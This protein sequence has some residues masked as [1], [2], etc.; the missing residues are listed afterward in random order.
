[1][2][3]FVSDCPKYPFNC[4][5]TL[6]LLPFFILPFSYSDNELFLI[7]YHC[8]FAQICLDSNNIKKKRN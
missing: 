4:D 7:H 3:L 6:F 1:M 8:L 2:P 5:F